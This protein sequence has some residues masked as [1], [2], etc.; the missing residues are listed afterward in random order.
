MQLKTF[1]TFLISLYLL[2]HLVSCSEEKLPPCEERFIRTWKVN[3]HYIAFENDSLIS[4]FDATFDITFNNNGAGFVSHPFVESESFEWNC[5]D[6]TMSINNAMN[7]FFALEIGIYTITDMTDT[8]ITL[9][10]H[11][12]FFTVRDTIE[13]HR[14]WL[15]TE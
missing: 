11:Q 6:I 12:L 14:T 1:V 8:T 9:E 5:D 3:Q 2:I 10:K 4:E 13:T 7:H 15:L